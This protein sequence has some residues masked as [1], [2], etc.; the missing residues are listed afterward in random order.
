MRL[1][2]VEL[3]SGRWVGSAGNRFDHLLRFHDSASEREC[4]SIRRRHCECDTGIVECSG[5]RSEIK[6]E[7]TA[8]L[9]LARQSQRK[10][11]ALVLRHTWIDLSERFTVLLEVHVNVQSFCSVVTLVVTFRRL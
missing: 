1:R 8:E 4:F 7:L 5:S 10:D 6:C 3:K 2:L 9:G 11:A